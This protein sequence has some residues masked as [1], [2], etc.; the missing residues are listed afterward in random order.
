[1]F[2]R[3]TGASGQV[4]QPDPTDPAYIVVASVSGGKDSTAMCLWLKEQGIEHRRVCMDTG[5]EHE[6]WYPYVEYIQGQLGPIDII[7]GKDGGMT[8]LINRKKMF[9]SRRLR[10]CTTELK[11]IPFLDAME[12]IRSETGREPISC[13]GIRAAESK[14]RSDLPEWD[15]IPA[16]DDGFDGAFMWRPLINW[17]E[18][19][20]IDIH[21]KHNTRPNPLYLKGAERV[22]CWPCI[23]ARKAEI[24]LL[25]DVDPDRV[26]LIERL[27]W[28]Q[29][30]EANAR[31]EAKG[32]PKP[33][34]RTWFHTHN[35]SGEPIDITNAVAWSRTS[36]GGKQHEMFANETEGCVRWGLCEGTGTPGWARKE[37]TE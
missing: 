20:V 5:W 13:V 4:I 31:A 10:F 11:V 3:K 27:E 30:T 34:P 36:H 15:Y 35:K 17:T 14:T 21:Q 33:A 24:R 7:Q 12:K 2:E 29:T 1:M 6:S 22:G 37:A 23:F 18:K 9:P 8:G 25:A 32:K 19:E 28:A 26:R 16:N